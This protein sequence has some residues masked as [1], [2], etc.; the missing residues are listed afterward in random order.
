MLVN[1]TIGNELFWQRV[2][3]KDK[4][5]HESGIRGKSDNNEASELVAQQLDIGFEKGAHGVECDRLDNSINDEI[6]IDVIVEQLEEGDGG[7]V[8]NLHSGP[9]F[10]ASSNI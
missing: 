10:Q 5:D 6:L 3:D 2:L 4:G 7:D 8:G 1:S 9:P